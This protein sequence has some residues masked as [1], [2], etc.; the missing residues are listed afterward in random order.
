MTKKPQAN[1]IT[2]NNEEI[3]YYR[4]DNDINGNPRYVVHFLSLNVKLADYGKIKG[5]TKYRAKWFGGGYVFQSHNLESDLNYYLK[6]VD[7]YY[8]EKGAKIK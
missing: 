6:L 2:V 1:N 7:N 4:I 3:T 5:L 8:N